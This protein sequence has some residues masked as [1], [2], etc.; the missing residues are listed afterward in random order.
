MSGDSG[1]M[2]GE[3]VNRIYTRIM[4]RYD[5]LVQMYIEQLTVDGYAPFTRPATPFEQYQKLV[6][7]QASGDPAYWQDP[8][9]Q[10]ALANLA[11]R[12]GQPAPL[13]NGPFGVTVPNNPQGQLQT[14]LTAQKQ[15]PFSSNLGAGLVQ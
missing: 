5:E 7:L 13:P 14:F 2:G 6:A 10:A 3:R 11:Q 8:R 1:R 12:F 9:A 4:E 15:G